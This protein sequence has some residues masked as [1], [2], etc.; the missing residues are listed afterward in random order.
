[1]TGL[2][3]YHLQAKANHSC[4][5]TCQAHCYDMSDHTMDFIVSGKALTAGH[6][7]T[8][9]YS[10]PKLSSQDRRM[11][12]QDTYNFLCSSER[13]QREELEERMAAATT[14]EP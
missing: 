10:D 9:T 7:L 14:A 12:L 1:M 2:G 11:R 13:C 5:P 6:E 4:E 8:L 3:L